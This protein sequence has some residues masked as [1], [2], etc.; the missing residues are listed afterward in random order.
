MQNVYGNNVQTS[1]VT[2]NTSATVGVDNGQLQISGA[3]GGAG[4]WT[5]VGAGTLFQ[6]GANT[7]TGQT[8]FNNGIV[9]IDSSQAALGSVVGATVVNSGA[10][11]QSGSSGNVFQ[12]ETL[13]LN[14]SGFPGAATP[15]AFIVPFGGTTALQG[16][17]VL[18][19]GAVLGAVAGG[20]LTLNGNVVG[21]GDLIKAG[22]GNLFLAT[23]N[24]YTGATVVRKGH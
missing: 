9:R 10:T 1:S 8:N 20:T 21:T 15:G 7:Y 11:L 5:K 14:G 13:I 4:D 18:N 3:I 17:I 19:S 16:T 2:L 23:A 24:T 6:N 22:P 12:A